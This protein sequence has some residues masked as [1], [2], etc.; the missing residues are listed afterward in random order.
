M[1]GINKLN[2]EVIKILR[3]SEKDMPDCGQHAYS[4]PRSDE[5]NEHRSYVEL[6]AIEESYEWI[7][8]RDGLPNICSIEMCDPPDATLKLEDGN[9]IC[10]EF[11]N[12][13]HEQ[14]MRRMKYLQKTGD[15]V[16]Y[17]FNWT[18]ETF[19]E[20]LTR[21]IRKK[22]IAFREHLLKSKVSRPLMLVCGSD[23][24]YSTPLL[25]NGYTINSDIF[26]YILLHFGYSPSLSS[27]DY[28]IIDIKS[29][30]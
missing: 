4:T 26:D 20:C 15:I 17:Y 8:K 18:P 24:V 5:R 11:T 30:V 7:M 2:D 3:Q 6:T 28:L 21:Q 29:N 27:Q 1:N 14:T 10:A 23:G 19:Q 22:E 13:I 12:I 16:R 9:E 25:V